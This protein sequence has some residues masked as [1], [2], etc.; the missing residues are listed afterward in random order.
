MFGKLLLLTGLS[1]LALSAQDKPKIQQVVPKA[2][3]P[4]SGK[5]MFTTYCAV[6]HGMNA[7]GGGPAVPA[8]KKAPP[9][10]TQ[11]TTKANGK[12]PENKIAQ[13]IRGDANM[14]AHG[15]KDM[16]IWGDVFRAMNRD[17]S[18]A[19]LRIRNLTEYIKSIQR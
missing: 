4:T 5:E 1:V 10:L 18:I 8:L 17:E 3:D 16:P 15:S 7:Q 13:T 9:D 12:F 19:Q 11:L 2:T 14:A 6:C